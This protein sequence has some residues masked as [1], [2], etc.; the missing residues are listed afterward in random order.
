ME[1]AISDG[2]ELKSSRS[3]QCT[4]RGR[5]I[6]RSRSVQ[7][8]DRMATRP[9]WHLPTRLQSTPLPP[10]LLPL[11]LLVMATPGVSLALEQATPEVAAASR[12]HRPILVVGSINV[13]ITMQVWDRTVCY[14]V[15][16]QL[17]GGVIAWGLKHAVVPRAI[18]KGSKTRE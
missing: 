13:D 18:G 5:R 12:T 17:C 3:I 14:S 9:R 16:V 7:C 2:I 11:L 4:D 6:Q 15:A 8:I 1:S 10:L